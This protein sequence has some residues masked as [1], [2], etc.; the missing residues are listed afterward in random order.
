[1]ESCLAP[2]CR[3]ICEP[4]ARL[5]SNRLDVARRAALK[6]CAHVRRKLLQPV[7]QGAPAGSGGSSPNQRGQR[8]WGRFGAE[9][10]F[11]KPA[12][13]GPCHGGKEPGMNSELL[14]GC[15]SSPSCR[16]D[17][18]SKAGVGMTSKRVRL[19][20]RCQQSS[21]S[22]FPLPLLDSRCRLGS[23]P[24]PAKVLHPTDIAPEDS[25]RIHIV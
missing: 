8:G 18:Q 17:S 24:F 1:M 4:V 5:G 19:Q 14:L 25:P 11:W 7:S 16:S 2:V 12:A 22:N 3:A 20:G 21:T 10:R 13:A 15:L 6:A 23:P 9:R